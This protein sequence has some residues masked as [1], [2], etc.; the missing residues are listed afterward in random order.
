MAISEERKKLNAGAFETDPG[1]PDGNLSMEEAERFIADAKQRFALVPE[2]VKDKLKGKTKEQ[3]P[4]EVA[5]YFKEQTGLT[6]APEVANYLEK[7]RVEMINGTDHKAKER[8]FA[9]LEKKMD[10]TPRTE[11]IDSDGR[12]KLTRNDKQ[13]DAMMD[14]INKNTPGNTI[15]V[16]GVA[17]TKE[18]FRKELQDPEYGAQQSTNRRAI[19]AD[20]NKDGIISAEEL[21]SSEMLKEIHGAVSNLSSGQKLAIL[22]DES[23]IENLIQKD[24]EQQSGKKFSP[25]AA[26]LLKESVITVAKS[27]TPTNTNAGAN[28][29][30]AAKGRVLSKGDAEENEPDQVAAKKPETIMDLIIAFIKEIFPG[31]SG[32]KKDHSVAVAKSQAAGSST[33]NVAAVEQTVQNVTGQKMDKL[34]GA[35][36]QREATEVARN[37]NN[38]GTRMAD[39]KQDQSPQVQHISVSQPSPAMGSVRT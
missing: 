5:K 23:L 28:G 4:E 31:L 37:L 34:L 18:Q 25:E 20:K 30:K 24:F 33:V 26:K 13:T 16:D 29:I 17:I 3:S 7:N 1:A 11:V 10:L 32:E 36:A 8:V 39:S 15:N 14:V 12:V 6:V 21:K 2:D 38:V 22:H 27:P 35:E 9:E 19:S